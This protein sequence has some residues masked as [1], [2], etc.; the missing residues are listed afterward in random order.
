MS[1]KIC[2]LSWHF[3]T[4]QI[5]LDYLKKQTPGQS[6][7]WKDMEAVIDPNEADYC[8]IMDGYRG[9]FPEDR[10]I[11]IGQHPYVEGFSPSFRTFENK[12]CL[13]RVRLDKHLNPGEWWLEYD[14]DTLVRLA[15]PKKDKVI[16]CCMTYQTHNA[17]YA[18]RVK[19]MQEYCKEENEQSESE[20]IHL[21]GRP[22]EKF[23]VDNILRPYYK[24]VLGKNNPD[25]YL[26]EH[27]QGK[28]ILS[29][30]EYTLEFDVGPTKN[31][32][33]E[34]FYDALLLWCWPIYFGSTNVHEFFP[35]RSF[36]VVDLYKDHP[37]EQ[38]WSQI[39]Q[40]DWFESLDAIEEARNLI[41]DKYQ[42]WPYVYDVIHNLGKYQ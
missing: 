1:K 39:H 7:K 16:A 35:E 42:I 3:A 13:A 27:T 11:Y 36:G 31:Y 2:F 37:L 34:R 24:G 38:V 26:N 17:M 21:Y 4:P 28:T 10:A 19:F 14:Y 29:Q 6:G 32:V 9:H 23:R 22:E 41:L 18:Q 33:S 20:A 12:H 30:Y 25:G 40:N 8:I 5:F 15:V